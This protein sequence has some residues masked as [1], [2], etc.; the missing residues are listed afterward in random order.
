MGLGISLFFG[1]ESLEYY[2]SSA[3]HYLAM[4]AQQFRFSRK[5][6]K[7]FISVQSK[8]QIAKFLE[9]SGDVRVRRDDRLFFENATDTLPLYRGD[10][11]YTGS[12]GN[13]RIEM[14]YGVSAILALPPNNIYEIEKAMPAS[15]LGIRR[16]RRN[17]DDLENQILHKDAPSQA[18]DGLVDPFLDDGKGE[19]V[20]YKALENVSLP[21]LRVVQE[22]KIVPFY[23]PEGNIFGFTRIFPSAYQV[24][25]KRPLKADAQGYLWL[26]K[27]TANLVS[28]E[29]LEAGTSRFLVEVPSAGEYVFQIFSADG[30]FRSR[31]FKIFQADLNKVALEFPHLLQ[32][33]DSLVLQ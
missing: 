31:S 16:V 23:F 7:K 20:T 10:R 28:S 6:S 13:T 27:P 21:S 2:F 18:R 3:T 26:T 9:I 14:T 24:R 1:E 11:I 22:T 32:E 12:N 30:S 29:F 8:V 25:L 4:Q 17:D 19:N 15:N 5:I 33:R